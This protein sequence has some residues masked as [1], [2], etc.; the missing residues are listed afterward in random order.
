[1]HTITIDKVTNL[2]G[3]HFK[4]RFQKGGVAAI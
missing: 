3:Y 1:M 2:E 4:P